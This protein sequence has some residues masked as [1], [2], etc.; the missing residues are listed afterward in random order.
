[1]L[2]SA[3]LADHMCQ[4]ITSWQRFDTDEAQLQAVAVRSMSC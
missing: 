3:Y 4:D 1:M 2:L